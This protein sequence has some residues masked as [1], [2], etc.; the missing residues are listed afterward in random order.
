MNVSTSISV[1]RANY[2]AIAIALAALLAI[3]LFGAAL[4]SRSQQVMEDEVKL[5]LR[6][7]AQ[8]GAM[9]FD[10]AEIESIHGI[11]DINS[12]QTVRAAEKLR[13]L[14]DQVE[15]IRFAYILRR[16]EDPMV[17]EFVADAD[18]LLSDSE[19]DRDH[20]G[21]VAEDEEPSFPGD[22]YDISTIPALQG[23]AFNEPTT[24]EE[25]TIDQ[26]GQ[27]MSGY[28]PIRNPKTGEVAGVLGLDMEAKQYHSQT[29]SI[30]TPASLLTLLV[31]ALMVGSGFLLLWMQRRLEEAKRLNDERTRL[32]QLTFHQ[33]GEPLT[34]FKWSA[35]MLREAGTDKDK[36]EAVAQHL[37]Y[38]EDGLGRLAGIVDALSEAE[39]VE[40]GTL[41]YEPKPVTAEKLVDMAMECFHGQK[42]YANRHIEIDVPHD[43][44]VSA[45]ARLIASILC[46]LLQN[47]ADYSPAGAAISLRMDVAGNKMTVTI[48]DKGDGIPAKEMPF[49]GEKFRRGEKAYLRKPDG[50][51]LSL[52]IARGVVAVAGSKLNIKSVE[53]HGTTVSF[54]LPLA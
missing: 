21:I 15:G 24:D 25:I 41:E 17:L 7:A 26:W 38:M 34:I 47:A 23:P 35:E 36:L 30:F 1:F 5:R 37:E 42:L 22:Q 28:A 52:Y 14:R 2:R 9:Q 49:I 33:I 48:A 46:R 6:T 10:A 11:L 44:N 16:T 4:F 12:A 50:K 27:L 54:T 43:T 53:G 31:G 32:L 18:M 51:G 45:D 8:V 40:K 19:L 3:C 29:V 39:R 20:D 13:M